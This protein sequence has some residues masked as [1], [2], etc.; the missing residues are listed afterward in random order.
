MEDVLADRD[1]L[2]L[3]Y[4]QIRDED[5]WVEARALT[6]WPAINRAARSACARDEEEVWFRFMDRAF[7]EW[8]HYCGG[9]LALALARDG[10]HPRVYVKQMLIT[11]KNR[12]VLPP[13]GCRHD[14]ARAFMVE[15]LK[16][17]PVWQE[18]VAGLVGH[19]KNSV[20]VPLGRRHW[21]QLPYWTRVLYNTVAS[22]NEQ[23]WRA[24]YGPP[25]YPTVL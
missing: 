12:Q 20:L 22:I 9:E 24:Q 1:L 16:D 17:T 10:K 18:W 2:H 3:I 7:H 14:D 19:A 6:H 4:L 8:I 13:T 15:D 5:P 23:R 11:H 25:V 21:S